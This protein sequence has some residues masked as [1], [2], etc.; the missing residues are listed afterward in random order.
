[1][2]SDLIY[3]LTPF[4]T[5]LGELCELCGKKAFKKINR[6]EREERKD[7]QR[8]Q[9]TTPAKIESACQLFR[10]QGINTTTEP[11]YK[12]LFGTALFMYRQIFVVAQRVI[13]VFRG[14][15]SLTLDCSVEVYSA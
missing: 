1:M 14:V 13:P 3:D 15:V 6:K 12:N 5:R 2:E 4:T 11:F 7:S 9:L 10:K 8:V